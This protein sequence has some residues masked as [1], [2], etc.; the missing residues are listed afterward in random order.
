MYDAPCVVRLGS[1]QA[2]S[3]TRPP[4]TEEAL[5]LSLGS[6]YV[7]LPLVC[8]WLFLFQDCVC[9]FRSH[10]CSVLCDICAAH[11]LHSATHMCCLF[12]WHRAYVSK[13]LPVLSLTL[14]CPCRLSLPAAR[15]APHSLLQ[16][17]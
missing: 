1:R 9:S 3:F 4:I 10:V 2:S 5:K 7:P 14:F 15:A 11:V 16:E 12:R 17:P 13:M 8:V 6:M